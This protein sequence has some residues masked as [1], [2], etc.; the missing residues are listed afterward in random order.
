MEEHCTTASPERDP[1]AGKT[2][3]RN[4]LHWHYLAAPASMTTHTGTMLC[5]AENVML[6]TA[7]SISGLMK[8]HIEP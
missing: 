8:M 5:F 1:L 7:I 2:S 4:F 3:E 6:V